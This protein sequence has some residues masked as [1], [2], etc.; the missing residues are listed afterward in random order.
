MSYN[1]FFTL[2]R[3]IGLILVALSV[4]VSQLVIVYT[5]SLY[6]A[7]LFVVLVIVGNLAGL[8]IAIIAACLFSITILYQLFSGELAGFFWNV[9]SM[10]TVAYIIGR[11]KKK[12]RIVD[13]LNG[14]IEKLWQIVYDSE[15]ILRNWYAV[16]DR[17]KYNR[18]VQVK[19]LATDLTT[20]VVGWI[21]YAEMRRSI[22]NEPVY[23]REGNSGAE[24]D[25]RESD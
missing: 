15:W 12:A 23:K 1:N 9:S 2:E 19:E 24:E 5:G 10:L 11:L 21:K 6:P 16:P 25:K 4:L 14:N 7:P 22:D 20:A 18:L 13:G 17:L 8:R 3:L